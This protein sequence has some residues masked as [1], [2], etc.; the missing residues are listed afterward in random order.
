M[1]A[2]ATFAAATLQAPRAPLRDAVRRALRRVTW[3]VAAATLA[4]AVAVECWSFLE[5]ALEASPRLPLAAAY[6][7]TMVVNVAIAFSMMFTTF[8]ADERVASGA[9]RV[10]AYAVAV[11][12]G[13][14]IGTLAQ[15]PLH[16]LLGL[17][18]RNEVAGV[19]TEVAAMQ[20]TVLFFEYLTWGSI[21]VWIY[22]SRR[23]E[24]SAA[25]RMS[26]AQLARADLQRRTLQAQLQTLQAQLEPR[27][28]L[29]TLARVRDRYEGD[30]ASGN[31]ML[32]RLIVYLRAALPRLR[33]SMSTLAQEIGLARAYVDMMQEY[34]GNDVAFHAEVAEPLRTAGMPPM[35]VL[36]LVNIL[37]A[38]HDNGEAGPVR[39][40][41]Q[42]ADTRLRV[43][44]SAGVG[45]AAP[46]TD[47]NAIDDIRQRLRALYGDNG[48]VAVEA[49]A[50]KVAR[51]IL[52]IPY[53]AADGHSR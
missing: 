35:L 30:P 48:S 2:P 45:G 8:I 42:R 51:V 11:V 22:V 19:A 40:A 46:A 23:A 18:W 43:W 34:L 44:I 47:G 37:L 27:F 14:A 26:A 24:A 16:R 17:A 49:S 33:E 32:G 3:R 6:A 10:P 4:I 13:S 25:A 15:W 9:R 36:P 31:A 7:S 29:D 5:A 38:G 52:E 28:L 39:I 12:A 1:T 50:R 41:A 21:I 53:E 20:P